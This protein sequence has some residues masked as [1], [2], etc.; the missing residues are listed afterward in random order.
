MCVS[1]WN[2]RFLCSVFTR[3]RARLHIFPPRQRCVLY[4]VHG[5]TEIKFVLC[6]IL[7]SMDPKEALR[8]RGWSIHSEGTQS[9]NQ[10]VDLTADEKLVLLQNSLPMS[11]IDSSSD[12]DTLSRSQLGDRTHD[13]QGSESRSKRGSLRESTSSPIPERTNAENTVE[14]ANRKAKQ[15]KQYLLE[16]AKSRMSKWA[17]RLFDPNR[18][19]GLVEPPTTIP[20]NDEFLT[21]FGRREKDLDQAKGTTLQIEH[22]ISDE[23]DTG[24]TLPSGSNPMLT[25]PTTV[26]DAKVKINNLKFTT[27][28]A[29]LLTVCSRFGAV[30]ECSLIM[31]KS[32]TALNAGRAYVTFEDPK[33]A[34]ACI[35]GLTALDGRPLRTTLA[36]ETTRRKTPGGSQAAA[37]YWA[38][39]I[40]TKCF[41]CDEVGHI[42]AECPNKPKPKPCSFCAQTDHEMYRCPLKVVC[43]NCGIPGHPSRACNMPRGLPE[44]RVCSIC[45]QSGHPTTRCRIGRPDA[46]AIQAAICMSCG[47][48]GHFLCK[49]MRWYFGLEGVTCANCGQAGHN[50][51]DCKRPI[52]E[53]CMRNSDLVERE[54][55]RASTLTS[56]QRGNASRAEQSANV[57]RGRQQSRPAKDSIAADNPRRAQSMPPPRPQQKRGRS[58]LARPL[59]SSRKAPKLSPGGRGATR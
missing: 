55:E 39:D 38:K 46:R 10:T 56:P 14:A 8:Q 5:K 52:L 26:T 34:E 36:S 31:D 18:P 29:D 54:I 59:V 57:A 11:C 28:E 9:S 30:N 44:R 17:A 49:E 41:R 45:F 50:I 48:P 12:S 25:N 23:D 43:F 7:F 6:S 13:I 24:D 22:N 19:R 53:D 32:N 2:H 4:I 27:S 51:F 1:V 16:A 42:E 35:K 47:R 40:S 37:R 20:L 33:S 58:P 3:A 15:K 21:A